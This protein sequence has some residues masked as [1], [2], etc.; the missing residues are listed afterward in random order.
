M[1]G[2]LTDSRTAAFVVGA[3][4]TAVFAGAAGAVAQ[5]ATSP[6]P[7]TVTMCISR[8]GVDVRF[9]YAAAQRTR[10]EVT[11]TWNVQGPVAERGPIG[12]AG[13]AGGVG[14]AGPTGPTGPAGAA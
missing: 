14:H 13:P 8:L 3:L 4:A 1:R 6:A 7:A 5:E 2:R 11:Q 9:V 12:P 10:G